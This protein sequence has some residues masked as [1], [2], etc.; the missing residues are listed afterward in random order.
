MR[1]TRSFLAYLA[2]QPQVAQPKLGALG[3]CMGGRMALAA[4]AHFPDQIAA[5]AAYHPGNVA[6]DKPDS[7]HLIAHQIKGSVYIGAAS[8][9]PSFPEEQKQRIEHALSNASVDHVIE[10]YPAKHGWVPSD[11]PMH[12]A[13]CAQRHWQ[14]LLGLLR[15][16]LPSRT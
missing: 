4:A 7:P 2:A 16:T 14:T 8:D 10:T 1:D 5:V 12:D 6:D 3:Y 9:D 13:A 15:R 11:T